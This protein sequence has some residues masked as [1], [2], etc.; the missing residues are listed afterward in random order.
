MPD[1]GS[2]FPNRNDHLRALKFPQA[3][4]KFEK[5]KGFF[6]GNSFNALAFLESRKPG[7]IRIVSL[8][9]LSHRPEPSYLDINIQ[10]G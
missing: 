7:F 8:T 9:Q 1:I 4:R 6:K 3:P 10:A 5:I 2:V